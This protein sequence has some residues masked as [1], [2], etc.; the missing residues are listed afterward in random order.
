MLSPQFKTGAKLT[1][2][3]ACVFA[4]RL[5]AALPSLPPD[6]DLG[7][8]GRDE[9]GQINVPEETVPDLAPLLRDK[10]DAGTRRLILFLNDYQSDLYR[11]TEQDIIDA[12][13]SRDLTP[14]LKYV[15][16][17]LRSDRKLIRAAAKRWL[18]NGLVN[19]DEL[20]LDH[21]LALLR[22]DKTDPEIVWS[23]FEA[24]AAKKNLSPFSHRAL[25]KI[26]LKDKEFS[27]RAKNVLIKELADVPS[28]TLFKRINKCSNMPAQIELAALSERDDLSTISDEA[29]VNVLEDEGTPTQVIEFVGQELFKRPKLQEDADIELAELVVKE[30][31]SDAA[32]RVAL[33][34]LVTRLPPED[35]MMLLEVAELHEQQH[36]ISNSLVKS[37]NRGVPKATPKALRKPGIRPAPPC[38]SPAD[39]KKNPACVKHRRLV[40]RQPIAAR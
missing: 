31:A 11:F 23:A 26:F 12:L 30:E 14:H 16:L 22:S 38:T 24:R 17:L 3:I 9:A 33:T 1:V 34:S 13:N 21:R 39:L 20:E 15:E 10:S 19:G 6:Y 7:D 8:E 29:M 37:Q 40:R 27:N 25:V 18:F 2:F 5:V 36:G 4:P 35:F 32:R 28:A